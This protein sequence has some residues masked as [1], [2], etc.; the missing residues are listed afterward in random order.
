MHPCFTLA[1]ALLFWS[2]ANSAI[3]SPIKLFSTGNPDGKIATLSRPAG[4]GSETETAD[5]FILGRTAWITNATFTGLIPTGTSLSSITSVG[6][7]L[8][9]VFPLDS[10]TPPDGRVVTRN[11]SPSDNA[12]KSFDSESLSFSA[13]VLNSSF[14]AANSVVNGIHEKPNQFTGGEGPV[15]GQEVE[16]DI[17][18]DTPFLIGATDHDFFRPEVELS[19]GGPFLW[20]SAPK[21]V[22]DPG[23]TF[24]FPGGPTTDL[25][26]WVRN[27]DLSP[28]W[29]R[30]G[31]DITGEGPFNA[32][33]SLSGNPVPEPS[34]LLMLGS[35]LVGFAGVIRRRLV[36]V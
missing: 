17:I 15:T 22:G 34:S 14:T 18:F 13:K 28:D 3:A 26:S 29:S 23:S 6:I 2:S 24:Q 35:G 12:F 21:P 33:F 16:F 20:L 8:Y 7:E 10:V 36:R 11:N 25:Q 31:T 27:E 5:D 9:H 30:I 1:A 19:D 32:S 4:A